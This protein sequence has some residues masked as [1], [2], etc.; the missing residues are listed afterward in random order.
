VEILDPADR[1]ARAELYP[2]AQKM[3]DGEWGPA[4]AFPKSGFGIAAP[5][6]RGGKGLDVFAG[7]LTP[8]ALGRG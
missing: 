6:I 8:Q 1:F 5:E 3:D 7:G 2:L 4:E